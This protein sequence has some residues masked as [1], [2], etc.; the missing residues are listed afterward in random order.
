MHYW[1]IGQ[2]P[3]PRLLQPDETLKKMPPTFRIVELLDEAPALIAQV[4]TF[5]SVHPS[6]HPDVAAAFAYARLHLSTE[7]VTTLEH[8]LKQSWT[9]GLFYMHKW[10]DNCQTYPDCLARLSSSTQC[11][12]RHTKKWPVFSAARV[13]TIRSALPRV[14]EFTLHSPPYRRSSF[15]W[16]LAL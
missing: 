1:L 8:Q 6:D 3:A 7:D 5:L 15:D 11:H 16:V 2:D 12:G 14:T 10:F 13:R 9:E 4:K